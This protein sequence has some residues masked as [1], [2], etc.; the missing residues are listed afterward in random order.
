M[1][2]LFGLDFVGKPRPKVVVQKVNRKVKSKSADTANPED[3]AVEKVAIV[4]VLINHKPL[5]KGDELLLYRPRAEKRIREV[6]AITIAKLA[7]KAKQGQ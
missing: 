4:P 6:E 1:S 3:E 7:K 2:S 5:K